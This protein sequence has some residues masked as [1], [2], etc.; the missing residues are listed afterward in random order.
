MGQRTTQYKLRDWLISRQRY[1]GTPIPV[2]YCDDCG[3]VGVPEDQLP[4]LLPV[5]VKFDTEENPLSRSE[6]FRHAPCPKCGRRARRETDTMAT[7]VD[8]SW[9]FLRY[10]D[11]KNE[12]LPFGPEAAYWMPVDQYIGGVEHAVLHLLYARFFTKVLR[13]LGLIRIDEPFARLF[14]QGMV[15]KEY[16]NPRSGETRVLKMSK[17]LGNTVDPEPAMDEFGADALRVFILF[18]SPAERQLD[19][20]DQQL[21]GCY[22]FLNRIW[23]FVQT[24]M[25]ALRVGREAVGGGEYACGAGQAEKALNRKARVTEELEGRFHFNTA[26]AA[27]MELLNEISAY[28]QGGEAKPDALYDATARML[29]SLSPFAPHLIDEIWSMIGHAES[30]F[31]RPWPKWDPAALVEDAIELPVQVNGKLRDR[32]VVAAAASNQEIE[33]AA[34]AARNAQP[35]LD[36]KTIRKVIIIPGKLVNIVVA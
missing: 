2:V 9:Y 15:C 23:R 32:I 27:A 5:D 31:A 10:T 16:T 1:W 22:R 14:T 12:A 11:S 25:E 13:D 21:E 17:S 29:L 26:I 18:A 8:S 7:F 30:I 28:A 4:V 33:E 6:A 34:K 20:S 24:Q 3:V 19:W 35:H 36:G